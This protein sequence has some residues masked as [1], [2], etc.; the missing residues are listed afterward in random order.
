MI[1]LKKKKLLLGTIFS[2]LFQFYLQSYPAAALYVLNRNDQIIILWPDEQ[3]C[4]PLDDVIVAIEVILGY[5]REIPDST[6][7]IIRNV[8]LDYYEKS[9]KP[10]AQQEHEAEY[11]HKS[12]ILDTLASKIKELPRKTLLLYGCSDSV[13]NAITAMCLS[14]NEEFIIIFVDLPLADEIAK[15]LVEQG[16]TQELATE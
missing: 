3:I 7:I 4:L 12:L 2:C 11:A 10:V 6:Q 14:R 1:F 9:M 16:F 5:L 15:K 13:C 8:S